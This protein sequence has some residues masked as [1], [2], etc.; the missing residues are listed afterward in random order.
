MGISNEN[1]FPGSTLP[2]IANHQVTPREYEAF[3]MYMSGKK[4][5]EIW[6]T[7]KIPEDTFYWWR[8]QIWWYRLTKN[9]TEQQR[10]YYELRLSQEVDTIVDGFIDVMK[11]RDVKS[12]GARVQGARAYMEMGENPLIKKHAVS[13]N[14]EKKEI[15]VHFDKKMLDALTEVE[16]LEL[17]R[18]GE[19]PVMKELEKSTPSRNVKNQSA[20]AEEE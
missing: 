9:Y 13:L 7:L 11:D 19:M 18:T 12:T 20:V 10:Q 15:N 1:E 5:I 17:A 8:Q 14:L 3:Q 4:I 16:L 2:M 6:K